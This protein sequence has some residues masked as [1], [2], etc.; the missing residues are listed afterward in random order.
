MYFFLNNP[1]SALIITL[2][3]QLCSS[4]HQTLLLFRLN[5]KSTADFKSDKT[6]WAHVKL[7]SSHLHSNWFETSLIFRSRVSLMCV[8][9]GQR[10]EVRIYG[11]SGSVSEFPLV[12]HTRSFHCFHWHN[13]TSVSCYTSRYRQWVASLKP[14]FKPFTLKH[15][16]HWMML[17]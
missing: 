11:S 7:F 13:N 10:S 5:C 6:N 4:T 8:C 9:W 3:C 16:F 1:V 17:Q 14:Q 15:G 2:T 12:S